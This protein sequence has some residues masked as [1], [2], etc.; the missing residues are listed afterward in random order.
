MASSSAATSGSG[1]SWSTKQAAIVV[2]AISVDRGI[3]GGGGGSVIDDGVV[4]TT[5][6]Y[7]SDK[8]VNQGDANLNL[9]AVQA[10]SLQVGGV[11]VV[12]VDD[13]QT[14][15][16]TDATVYS[17]EKML[18][19]DLDVGL[20]AVG[21]TSVVLNGGAALTTY[22]E[23]SIAL[24]VTGLYSSDTAMVSFSKL[25][26]TVTASLHQ[27]VPSGVIAGAPSPIAIAPIPTA[28]LPVDDNAG[29]FGYL[30]GV[31]PTVVIG[32][33]FTDGGV[34]VFTDLTAATGLPLAL[35]SIHETSMTWRALP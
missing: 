28:F 15:P 14:A 22:A 4:G 6:T 34:I 33:W 26:Q 13:A 3:S 29:S 31:N 19:G 9:G 25:N 2:D 24:P 12:V 8:L 20:G 35:T 16:G 21:A 30:V 5:T 11:S 7:S 10:T 23:L 18:A 27:Y 1:Q 32:Q 17:T